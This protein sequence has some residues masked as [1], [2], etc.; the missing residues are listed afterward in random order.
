MAV[1][2]F[3]TLDTLDPR[4]KRVLLRVD[5]NVPMKDG[6]ISDLTRIERVVPTI[7]EL[8]N[9]GGRVIVLSHFDRPKGKVVPGL[10]L[11]PIATALAT[12]LG[13]PVSFAHDC[14]G[15][16][17]EAAA[18]SL[19][20]GE[21][22]LLE[23]TRFQPGE[24]T[25][26]P[27]LAAA[28][29]KLGDIYVNDAF[30]AAHRAHA[31]T[32]GVAEH[33]PSYAGRLMEAELAALDAALENPQRPVGAIVGGAKVSTKLALLENMLEKVDVLA[34]GGA[35]ANTF[36]AAKG[37]K[38]G[39]SLKEDDMLDT[40]R[41]II[42]QAKAKNCELILPI[43]VVLAE[44]FM[45]GAPTAVAAVTDIPDGW[46]ALDVGPETVALLKTKLAGL[47]TLVWNGP[48]GVFELPPFDEATNA[49]AQEAAR[50]TK[51]GNLKTIAGG[52]DT[53][54]ALRHA[55]VLEDMTYVSTAGGA[56][57]EW[58]EG[59]VLPGLTALSTTLERTIPV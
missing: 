51:A 50:L 39:K 43:D 26:A 49:V 38:V 24:E 36:L 55:G 14:I 42:E 13:K 37:Y 16:D 20:D 53:V 15:P 9:K 10:S 23:N 19:Q 11:Q 29:A 32:A 12:A 48:L 54:S 2:P 6:V 27:D 8:A 46:M 56:F 31:S 5:L 41:Q 22:L 35:M 7:A 40:A 21:V 44:D 30:S 3:N 4:G 33:L 57:L 52:G 34:V 47:K 17:A 25:N 1:I 18:A 28:L 45:A 59:K 58:L